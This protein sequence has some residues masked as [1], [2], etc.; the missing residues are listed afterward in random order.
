VNPLKPRASGHRVPHAEGAAVTAP[1]APPSSPVPVTSS[2]APGARRPSAPPR[3]DPRAL[4]VDGRARGWLETHRT[5]ADDESS[6]RRRRRRGQLHVRASCRCRP[7][8]YPSRGSAGRRLSP[9][10]GGSRLRAWRAR[11]RPRRWDRLRRVRGRRFG[12]GVTEPCSPR[13][14]V[15]TRAE[16]RCARGHAPELEKRRVGMSNRSDPP[17]VAST[18]YRPFAGARCTRSPTPHGVGRQHTAPLPG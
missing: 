14:P 13:P 5:A 10:R 4:Q 9:S 12:G 11:Q 17:G 16:R 6:Q 18:A 3:R 8:A 1:R 2:S 7:S 15:R